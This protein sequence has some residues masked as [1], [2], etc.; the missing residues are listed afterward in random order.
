MIRVAAVG[1]VE[2]LADGDVAAGGDV[3]GIPAVLRPRRL[4][5][6][7]GVRAH[8]LLRGARRA[9]RDGDVEDGPGLGHPLAAF[10][11]PGPG[12]LLERA[13]PLVRGLG[14]AAARLR[15]HR[16]ALAI[17]RQRQR[18]QA[19][20]QARALLQ[21]LLR[22]PG[23]LLLIPEPVLVEPLRA[24]G[25]GDDDL[26]QLPL[27]DTD[28]GRGQ[29][30]LVPLL[31]R[32]R[33]AEHLRQP[34]QIPGIL[35][36]RQVQHRIT[37]EQRPRPPDPGPVRDPPHDHLTQPR[38]HRPVMIRLSPPA[39]HPVGAGHLRQPD[40]PLRL[41]IQPELD[42][43]A[44]QRAA[45]LPDP[46]LHLLQHH[47]PARLHRQPGKPGR[48]RPQ[49]RQHRIRARRQ[50][51][52]PVLFHLRLPFR[53]PGFASQDHTERKPHPHPDTPASRQPATHSR[54]AT[55]T[56]HPRRVT[57]AGSVSLVT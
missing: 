18:R 44:Q 37:R 28:P 56:R 43:P 4:R 53:S 41:G 6:A 35:A 15:E 54:R 20:L 14:P 45:L 21:A 39:G 25:R 17:R 47:R 13:D 36:R 19:L 10:L 57:G 40:L 46:P 7:G 16:H 24:G 1:L 5:A 38:H 50:L 51:I 30:E 12:P 52:Q 34:L 48:Q 29:H 31:I 33:P 32:H 42:Q 23:R 11:L 26:L 9:V 22:V 2:D 3:A 49:P 8:D 27:A 55:P